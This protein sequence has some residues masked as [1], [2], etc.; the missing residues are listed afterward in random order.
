MHNSLRRTKIKIL[1]AQRHGQDLV[2]QLLA[3]AQREELPPALCPQ[4]L[5]AIERITRARLLDKASQ[6]TLAIG[7]THFGLSAVQRPEEEEIRA[8]IAREQARF[9]IAV[10]AHSAHKIGDLAVDSQLIV[11][12][13]I[14]MKARCES[15]EPALSRYLP[16]VKDQVALWA[17]MVHVEMPPDD[18]IV[19]ACAMYWD[20]YTGRRQAARAAI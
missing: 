4:Q 18:R 11:E 19:S 15:G 6:T 14:A 12:I 20:T 9:A 3:L 1:A 2:G 10:R 8:A 7:E 13:L 17:R 5:E 16:V